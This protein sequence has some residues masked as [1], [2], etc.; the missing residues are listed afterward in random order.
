MPVIGT[1]PEPNAYPGGIVGPTPESISANGHT[2]WIAVDDAHELTVFFK[3]A[4][5]TGLTSIEFFLECSPN[6]DDAYPLA[7]TAALAANGL[8]TLSVGLATTAGTFG[9]FVR[10]R[11][12]IVGTGTV[13]VLGYLQGK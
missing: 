5:Y 4:D 12:A 2:D 11:W 10:L 13:A 7:N 8:A 9:Y 3:L 1:Q 6:E